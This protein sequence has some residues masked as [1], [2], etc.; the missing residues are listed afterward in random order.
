MGG[1]LNPVNGGALKPVS[2]MTAGGGFCCFSWISYVFISFKSSKA[3][4][5][6]TSL[7]GATVVVVV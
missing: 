3:F 2:L 7:S 5:T 6:F 4:S 1:A